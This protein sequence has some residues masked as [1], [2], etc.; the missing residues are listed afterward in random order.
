MSVVL[1]YR[2]STFILPAGVTIHEQ[3]AHTLCI[4]RPGL[5]PGALH[6]TTLLSSTKVGL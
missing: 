4:D 3:L 5:G 6:S 2:K 1:F